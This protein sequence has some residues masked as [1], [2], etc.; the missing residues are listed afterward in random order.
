M[1]VRD[2]IGRGR[3]DWPG[4][5]RYNVGRLINVGMPV[6]GGIILTIQAKHE[7]VRFPP[8]SPVWFDDID[9]SL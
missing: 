2:K 5:L 7:R 3:T 8:F 1:R 4:N 9:L 6:I